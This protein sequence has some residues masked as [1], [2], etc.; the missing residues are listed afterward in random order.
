MIR[1]TEKEVDEVW[2]DMPGDWLK[3]FGYQQFAIALQNKLEVKQKQIEAE[4]R[5]EEGDPVIP[6]SAL[7]HGQWYYGQSEETCVAQWNSFA[8]RFV[9]GIKI[10]HVA[11]DYVLHE[12]LHF[13][14]AVPPSK[15]FT[16]LKPIKT[17]LTGDWH[18]WTAK[19]CYDF[20]AAV[21]LHSIINDIFKEQ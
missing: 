1:L 4:I 17:S 8:N 14:D 16:P 21:K 15:P 6:K 10:E 2:K 18:L 11:A 20:N 5:S 13:H 19:E 7:V 3:S 12:Q 9:F